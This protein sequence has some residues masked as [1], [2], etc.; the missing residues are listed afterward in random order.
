M[1]LLEA[2]LER[3]CYVSFAGI[4]TF[5]KFDGHDVVR[6]VPRD[7]LLAETDAPY[8]APVPRRGKRNE[9]AFVTHVVAA[10]GDIRGEEL[11]AVAALTAENAERFYALGS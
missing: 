5:S 9:P 11:E 10:L 6:A 4:I 1:R 8:L 2:G 7:R 3:G